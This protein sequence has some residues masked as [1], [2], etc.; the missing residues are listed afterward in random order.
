[1]PQ[2]LTSPE[3]F[4]K[5]L[6][7][8][9]GFNQSTRVTE[10]LILPKGSFYRGACPARLGSDSVE[11]RIWAAP[12]ET[13]TV[14]GRIPSS[15]NCKCQIFARRPPRNSAWRFTFPACGT[16][17]LSD[18]AT[19]LKQPKEHWDQRRGQPSTAARKASDEEKWLICLGEA[20]ECYAATPGQ[21]WAISP[22]IPS[23]PIELQPDCCRD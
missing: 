12:A 19:K 3:A 5:Y 9:G 13:A 17:E 8:R 6:E 15:F 11:N 14:Y 2:W 23:R 10:P 18:L 16:Y 20:S 21:R 1:M 4:T 22:S 7:A